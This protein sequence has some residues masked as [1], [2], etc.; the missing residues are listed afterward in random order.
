MKKRIKHDR[1]NRNSTFYS[2]PLQ[3][4]T[5]EDRLRKDVPIPVH[6][7]KRLLAT[8]IK[9]SVTEP[10]TAERNLFLAVLLQAV[11][12]L[13]HSAR[14]C[15]SDGSLSIFCELLGIDPAYLLRLVTLAGF[16][17]GTIVR[18]VH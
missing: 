16:P 15:W 17:T 18:S 7:R 1:R 4:L 14:H 2:E 12:D 5:K 3:Y 11:A 13:P 9:R 10:L 6:V 8:A